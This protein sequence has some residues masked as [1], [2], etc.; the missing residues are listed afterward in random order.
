MHY[1]IGVI[2]PAYNS[3]KTLSNLFE[4]IPRNILEGQN[5]IIVVND[6]SRDNTA[7]IIDALRRR[8]ANLS[9]IDCAKNSGYGAAQKLGFKQALSECMD[10][11]VLLHADGQ[12]PP[13]IIGE[14]LR[15]IIEAKAEVVGG[16]RF[17]KGDVL[18]QGMP[19][20]R[21]VGQI[22]LNMLENLVFRKKLSIY[23]SGYRAY[24]RKALELINFDG[25]SNY[26][27]FDTE[28]LIGAF[29]NNLKVQEVPIPTCYGEE[30][31]HLNPLRYSIGIVS[32]LLRYM[33][34]RY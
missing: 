24:S 14:I 8:Y 34:K 10:A 27:Y 33:F 1:K 17:L 32:I 29:L 7:D 18:G 21:Y 22:L 19:F 5:R 9:V 20:L 30:K 13:E 28:M 11:A 25:Y 16:S 6:G 23:H 2:I 12:Y 31:S 26:F 4:R 15:P 3:G